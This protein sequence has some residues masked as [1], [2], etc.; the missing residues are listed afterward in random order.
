MAMIL[1]GIDAGKTQHHCVANRASE[2]YRGEGKTDAK[3]AGVIA[4]QARIR[5][6]LH[7]LRADDETV[8]DLKTSPA[9]ERTWSPTAPA[10]ST[11]S[12]PN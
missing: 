2:S 9:V 5:R 4:D 1:A 12:A 8:T 10:P 3:D 11:G 7:L 6:D